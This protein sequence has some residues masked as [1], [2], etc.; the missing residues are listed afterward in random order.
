MEESDDLVS[1]APGIVDS[2]RE[3][4]KRRMQYQV[5]YL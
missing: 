4:E 5:C 3:E 1:D 2:F